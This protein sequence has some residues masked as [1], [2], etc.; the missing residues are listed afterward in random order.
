MLTTR[1]QRPPDYTLLALVGALTVFGLVMVYSASFVIA[2]DE[3]HNQLYYLMRQSI[4]AVLGLVLLFAGMRIDYRFWRRMTLPIMIGTLL[5]LILVILLPESMTKRGGAERWI[6][7]GPV[8]IQPTEIA[9]F[10]LVIYLASWLC[11]RGHKMRSMTISLIPFATIMGIIL[12]LVML[13]PN[14][15]TAIIL[16]VIGVAV[17]FAAGANLMHI[18]AGLFMGSALGWVL[19]QTAAYRLE[20]FIVFKDPWAFPRDGGFQPIHAMYALASGGW[21]GRGLGQSRQKF[22]WLPS[23][24]ADAIF[25]VIG[26]E[27]GLIGTLGVLLAFLFFTYRGLRIATRSADPFAALV[28]IGITTWLTFQAFV[29]M[30]VV[31]QVIPFT[32][33]TL[34][35]ISYGGS[36]LAMCLFATGVLLNI[37]KYVDD[38]PPQPV[39]VAPERPQAR[40]QRQFAAIPGLAALMRRGNRGPRVSSAGRSFG[41]SR[42]VARVTADKQ[43]GWRRLTS[44]AARKP[45]G[46]GSRS[47]GRANPKK[48]ADTAGSSAWRRR[49]S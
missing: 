12:A 14:L 47:P 31:A 25:S 24:H 23:A 16:G 2:V 49:A 38:Q 15:S 30:A 27:L 3:G 37:S 46:R 45:S 10:S 42:R 40:R 22:A 35:F 34:P 21:I 8:G 9:K 6:T 48:R 43:T 5:L 36:S 20:R 33:V 28:A 29:N 17:Y 7:F 41:F 19:M 18:G 11:L 32:G 13:Q 4:W 39:A 1:Q 26:E 44:G